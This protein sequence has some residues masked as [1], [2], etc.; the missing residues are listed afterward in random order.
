[1]DTL[2]IHELMALK[3]YEI[4]YITFGYLNLSLDVEWS[5]V[6]SAKFLIYQNN[7]LLMCPKLHLIIM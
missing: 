5:Q 1:M 6:I 7:Y 2:T 4:L 3:S